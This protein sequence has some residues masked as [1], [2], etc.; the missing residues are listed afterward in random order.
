MNAP[1]STA[2]YDLLGVEPTA[3]LADL[4][5]AYRRAAKSAHPDTGGSKEEF[6][7]LR[8]A[9]RVL[10]NPTSRA[11]Y[12]ETGRAEEPQTAPGDSAAL[13]EIARALT[14]LLTSDRDLGGLD[15][16]EELARQFKAARAPLMQQRVKLERVRDRAK[17]AAKRIKRK[18][19]GENVIEKLI[20]KSLDGIDKAISSVDMEVEKYSRAENILKEYKTEGVKPGAGNADYQIRDI[21]AL[22][23]ADRGELL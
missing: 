13:E 14:R 4:R 11:R 16:I 5:R 18:E 1:R 15:I 12:D 19:A 20:D 21:A 9:Y 23:G 6:S 22:F 8:S 2:L 17:H 10:S 7:R 3:S